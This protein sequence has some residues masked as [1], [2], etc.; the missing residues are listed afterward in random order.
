MTTSCA[1]NGIKHKLK[2]KNP[3]GKNRRIIIYRKRQPPK[4]ERLSMKNK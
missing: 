1:L 2:T 3:E 4:K